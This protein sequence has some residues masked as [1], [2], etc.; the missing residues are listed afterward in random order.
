MRVHTA[1][2][3]SIR[4]VCAGQVGVCVCVGV[5]VNVGVKVCMCGCGGEWGCGWAERRGLEV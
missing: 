4:Y 2:R 1:I 5:G 3:I